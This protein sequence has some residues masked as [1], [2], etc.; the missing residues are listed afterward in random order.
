MVEEK[1]K[2][3]RKEGEIEE[4][5]RTRD[6][7]ADDQRRII[8]SFSEKSVGLDDNRPPVRST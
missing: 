3:I 1:G 7:E 4:Q 6:E 5:I 8:D 2:N